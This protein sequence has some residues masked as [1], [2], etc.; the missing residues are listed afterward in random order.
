MDRLLLRLLLSLKGVGGVINGTSSGSALGDCSWPSVALSTNV[1]F[2]ADTHLRV[3][4]ASRRLPQTRSPLVPEGA[5]IQLREFLQAGPLQAGLSPSLPL[6]WST[7]LVS[8]LSSSV[9]F[10]L[11]WIY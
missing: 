4:S 2:G 6:L 10:W 8:S 11:L 3:R 5:H 1:T 9:P 7:C